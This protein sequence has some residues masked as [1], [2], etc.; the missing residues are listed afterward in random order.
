MFL[1]DFV[2]VV[3]AFPE[4]R[5]QFCSGGAWLAPL[6]TR[7]AGDAELHLRVGPGEGDRGRMDV[8]VRLG[9]CSQRGEVSVV[10]IRW[11]AA[12]LTSFFPVLDGN[13]ELVDLG[14]GRCRLGLLA[15]Y[16]PPLDGIGR[17]VD[18]A[19]L[20]RVAQST[21]RS[22]LTDVAH[23]LESVGEARDASTTDEPQDSGRGG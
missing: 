19:V 20:H 23:S 9:E 15:T 2:D 21:V 10:P 6:A 11:E 18:R 16:R 13:I 17:L 3:C 14:G 22:F 5:R 12:R 7:A 8:R 4:A 1:E